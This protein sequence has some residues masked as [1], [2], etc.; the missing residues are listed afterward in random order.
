MS[1]KTDLERIDMTEFADKHVK[2]AI[3]NICI[4]LGK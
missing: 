2:T 4:C 1:I 3:I